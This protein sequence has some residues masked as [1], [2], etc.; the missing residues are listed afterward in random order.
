LGLFSKKISKRI[1]PGGTV[2]WTEYFHGTSS[3]KSGATVTEST[4]MGLPAVWAGV[5]FI[6]TTKAALPLHVHRKTVN[7]SEIATGHIVDKILSV[8][9]N[10]YQDP[11]KF[12]ETCCNFEL[13]TGLLLTKKYTPNLASC[14]H[15]SPSPHG[16]SR[17]LLIMRVK[18][19]TG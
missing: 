4:V 14:P 12:I 5:N 19:F 17:G 2:N 13:L 15:Y 8:R 11:F 1:H 3:S 7:G 18:D 6:S 16:E 9:P 10:P